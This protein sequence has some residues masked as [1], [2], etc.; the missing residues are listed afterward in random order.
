MDCCFVEEDAVLDRFDLDWETLKHV[1]GFRKGYI[2]RPLNM[3]QLDEYRC[4]PVEGPVV[5]DI[6]LKRRRNN[7]GAYRR[8][9]GKTNVK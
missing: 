3:F 7:T 6:T 5:D 1:M 9:G 8:A 4:E 2:F